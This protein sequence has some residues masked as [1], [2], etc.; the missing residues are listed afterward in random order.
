M[1]TW[2][3]N[4]I[5]RMRGAALSS[6]RPAGGNAERLTELLGSEN[7]M[8]ATEPLD[9]TKAFINRV[10]KETDKK[11][12]AFIDIEDAERTHYKMI[13]FTGEFRSAEKLAQ[14]WKANMERRLGSDKGYN[15]AKLLDVYCG[16]NLDL[17]NFM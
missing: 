15:I 2:F 13:L 12:A 9:I 11:H 16:R 4:D 7:W 6:G 17:N 8:D 14:E 10:K 1:V 5:W 3:E